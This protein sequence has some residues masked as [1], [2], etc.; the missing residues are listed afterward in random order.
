MRRI[1]ILASILKSGVVTG[2]KSWNGGLEIAIRIKNLRNVYEKRG[3][4]N[5]SLKNIPSQGK[6]KKL[7][8][9]NKS[10]IRAT[11]SR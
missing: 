10:L 2:M 1:N 4:D 9:Q 3:N 5:P 8:Q 7:P 11:K 6:L